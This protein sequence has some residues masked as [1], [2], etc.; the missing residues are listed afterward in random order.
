MSRRGQYGK[1]RGSPRRHGPGGAAW[2]PTLVPD[3]DLWLR[4]DLGLTLGAPFTTLDTL[5]WSASSATTSGTQI[6]DT[7]DGAPAIHYITITPPTARAGDRGVINVELKA[8][9][10]SIVRVQWGS[11]PGAGANYAYVDLTTGAVGSTGGGT[12]SAT[13]A[14]SGGG[15]WRLTLEG[16]PNATPV[17]VVIAASDSGVGAG[18]TGNNADVTYQGDGTGTVHM[19]NFSADQRLVSAWA[20]QS[21]KGR[22]VTQ[23]SAA[24][25]PTWVPNTVNGR[26]ALW[27]R[28]APSTI[29]E[30]AGVAWSGQTQVTMFVVLRKSDTGT[31]AE[32]VNKGQIAATSGFTIQW[33]N[34][35]RISFSAQST[36]GSYNTIGT[37]SL[38]ASAATILF[39]GTVDCS[40]AQA[41]EIAI[42]IDGVSQQLATITAFDSSNMD[43]TTPYVVGGRRGG[44]AYLNGWIAEVI[45]YTRKLSWAER[46]LVER[47]L[48]TRYGFTLPAS[49]PQSIYGLAAWWRADMGVTMDGS[50]KVSAWA[51]QSGNGRHFLQA[52]GSQQPTWSATAGPNGTP[53]LVF[54]EADDS[55]TAT[56]AL[57]Q[58]EHVFI[59][60]K[61]DTSQ[62]NP[63][64]FDGGAGTGNRM[65]LYSTGVGP[66]YSGTYVTSDG[67]NNVVV[68]HDPEAAFKM[69]G[70]LFKGASSQQSVSGV[71]TVTGNA[72]TNGGGGIR[73]NCF[74]SGGGYAGITTPEALVYSRALS[75]AEE[76]QLRT[77]YSAG[78]YGVS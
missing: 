46:V 11:I 13:T 29:M 5:G 48:A 22:H 6:T 12:V 63:S 68:V 26:P 71:A 37:P 52:T 33:R 25:Q 64:I 70:C 21:G 51:D 9:T 30:S 7:N 56:W 24:Q 49:V 62:I 8:G 53:A 35:S 16:V 19:R 75:A 45:V 36:V 23:V 77:S 39:A 20:D 42:F 3:C 17:F 15:W 58:P 74:G 43:G 18:G 27:F 41:D 78:R 66:A 57:V 73:L 2:S 44:G 61:M 67:A 28:S 76:A 10:K 40:Q 4:A 60:A 32:P 14:A 1:L 72:G 47:Y 34:D 69:Y 55:M 31:L 50:S 38:Y 65:R 59:V 54:D